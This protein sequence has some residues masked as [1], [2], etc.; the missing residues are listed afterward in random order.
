[1]SFVT[2]LAARVASPPGRAS[3]GRFEVGYPSRVQVNREITIQ[4]R[5]IQAAGS[6]APLPEQ[7]AGHGEM[8]Q[9]QWQ[10]NPATPQG[11]ATET[12]PPQV[13]GL[14]VA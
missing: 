10:M 13:S 4:Q 7:Q 6:I 12:E 3:P 11:P 14:P 8:A 5:L 2:A 1:M 9:I